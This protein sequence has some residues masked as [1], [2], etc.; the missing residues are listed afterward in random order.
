[1]NALTIARRDLAAYF[2]GYSGYVIVAAILFGQGLLFN[3]FAMGAESARYSHEVLEDFFYING[4]AAMIA[5][6]LFTMRALAEERQDGTDVL[7]R[8]STARDGEV[9]FGKYLAAMGMLVLVT[10]LTV[11]MPALIFVNGKVSPA[12]L[13]VGY[14]G[15]LGIG[16]ATTAM[17]VFGSSLFRSQM[18]AGIFSGVL[19]LTFLTAWMMSEVTS[20]PFSELTAYAAIFNQHFIPFMEGQLHTSGLVYYATLTAAFLLLATRVL[21]ESRWE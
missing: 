7:L 21:Y 16:S 13:A 8:T 17:G 3:A 1:M 6:I 4:G 2:H 18:A 9:V 20:P 11:Y 10:S 19:V 14:L 12:H 15:V 5:S